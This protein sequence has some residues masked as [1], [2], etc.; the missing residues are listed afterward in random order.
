MACHAR[1]ARTADAARA[2]AGLFG[3]TN[4]YFNVAIG[5]CGAAGAGFGAFWTRTGASGR[6]GIDPGSGAPT[7]PGAAAVGDSAVAGDSDVSTL[8]SSDTTHG[9]ARSAPDFSSAISC[10]IVARSDRS[11]AIS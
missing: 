4:A 3:L 8:T 1:P 6:V 10:P 9:S 7:E 11:I 2:R 5:V